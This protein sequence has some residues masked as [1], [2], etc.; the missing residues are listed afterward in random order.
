MSRQLTVDHAL[1]DMHHMDRLMAPKTAGP[2][3]LFQAI[4]AALSLFFTQLRQCAP[5]RSL[6]LFIFN[7]CAEL[8]A[9]AHALPIAP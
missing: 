3:S 4:A 7:Q 1:H 9:Y 5:A 2:V 6:D 8:P